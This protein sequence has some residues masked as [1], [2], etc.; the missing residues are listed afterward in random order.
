MA[1]RGFSRTLQ[2]GAV[3]QDDSTAAVQK[4][5]ERIDA[6]AGE[7]ALHHAPRLR[8]ERGCDACCVD[9]LTVFLVEAQRI[10]I[11]HGALLRDGTPHPPGACAFL[12]NAG[13]CR[14]YADRPYVCRTQGL[15]LRWFEEDDSEEICEKRDIC[16]LN[17]EGPALDELPEDACW[18]I[19]PVELELGNLQAE[20]RGPHEDRIALRALFDRTR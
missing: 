13:E 17:A 10:R 3:K 7:L 12:G 6:R 1:G 11:H 15:P 14:I 19:G 4:L 18:L 20:T 2:V 9:D 5:H 16:P 8:C